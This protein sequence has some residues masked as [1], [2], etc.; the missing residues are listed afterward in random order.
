MSKQKNK[1]ITLDR[2][3]SICASRSR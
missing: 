1:S 2:N 3:N